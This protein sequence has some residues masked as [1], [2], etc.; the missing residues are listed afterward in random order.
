[1]RVG[2]RE[3]GVAVCAPLHRRAY[4]VAIADVD[5]VAHPDLV[6][7]VDHRCAG[8]R[9]QQAVH[10]LDPAA[11]LPQQRG[12]AAPDPQVDARLRV[13]GIDPIHVVPVL[14]GYHLQRQLVVIAQEDGPLTALGDRR[15]LLEN[16][17]DGEA[18]LHVHGHE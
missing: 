12:Q 3:P 18:V 17:D 6:A 7:V 10:Q 4:A 15:R 2:A 14:V 1:M 16:V 11:I 8:Q 9:E 5:I 13:V